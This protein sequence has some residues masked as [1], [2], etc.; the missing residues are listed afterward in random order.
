MSQPWVLEDIERRRKAGQLMQQVLANH[1]LNLQNFHDVIHV[2]DSF[3]VEHT[4]KPVDLSKAILDHMFPSEPSPSTLYHYT[5]LSG[6]AG[7]ASSAELHLFPIRKR[8]DEGGELK[9]FAQTHGLEGYFNSDEG[10]PFYKELSNDLFYASMTRIPPKDPFLMWS[11]FSSGTGVRLEFEV[12]AKAAQLRPIRYEQKGA[13]T[14]LA[15]INTVLKA[16]QMPPFVPY[17]ISQIGAFY[18]SSLVSAEDE[19]RLLVKRYKEGPDLTCSNGK[20]NYWPLPIG[21]MNE[22]CDLTLKGIHVAP[23]GELSAV[24]SATAGTKFA[25]IVPTGP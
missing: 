4:D 2:Q 10:A 13:V 24:A 14:L 17:T 22:Y 23:G 20:Y 16:H 5:D 6:L 12:G 25:L 21:S 3:I 9:A 15:D 8:I 7:I 11:A 18:L 1:G 19:V